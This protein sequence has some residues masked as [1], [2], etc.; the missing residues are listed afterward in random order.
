MLEDMISY[1]K[2]RFKIK[3]SKTIYYD[4]TLEKKSNKTK[5]K[6]ADRVK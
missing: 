1:I 6:K 3:R 5:N 2:V 4:I